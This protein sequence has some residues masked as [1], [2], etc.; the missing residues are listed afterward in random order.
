MYSSI[1][2]DNSTQ[3]FYL[4]LLMSNLNQ[5]YFSSWFVFYVY[6]AFDTC[7]CIQNAF[8]IRTLF[9]SELVAVP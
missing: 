1:K 2:L 6:Y 8:Q 3:N 7:A 9:A 4:Y 5:L